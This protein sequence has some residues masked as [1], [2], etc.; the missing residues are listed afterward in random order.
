MNI[1]SILLMMIDAVKM[2]NKNP[3]K[4]ILSVDIFRKLKHENSS[5]LHYDSDAIKDS[6]MQ[7]EIETRPEIDGQIIAVV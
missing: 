2:D 6:F 7:I 5:L 3:S 4:I 1:T